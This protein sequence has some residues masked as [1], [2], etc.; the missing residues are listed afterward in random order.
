MKKK[1]LR[2]MSMCSKLFYSDIFNVFNVGSWWRGFPLLDNTNTQFKIEMNV[3]NNNNYLSKLIYIDIYAN[4][5]WFM[6]EFKYIKD[7][8]YLNLNGVVWCLVQI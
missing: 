5:T 1:R 8:V 3:K 7:L 2:A 4:A 6:C